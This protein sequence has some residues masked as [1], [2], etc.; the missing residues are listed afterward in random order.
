MMT[1]GARHSILVIGFDANFCYLMERYGLLSTYPLAFAD[2]NEDIL[3]QVKARRPDL[4]FLEVV[5]PGNFAQKL[6]KDIKANRETCHIPIVVCS[7]QDSE[8]LCLGQENA[9]FHLR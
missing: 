1:S 2:H 6:M 3:A 5:H 4:I 7:W 9:D 8:E